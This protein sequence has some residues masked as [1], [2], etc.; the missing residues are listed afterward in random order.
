MNIVLATHNRHK[1]RELVPLLKEWGVTILTLDQ[2]PDISELEESGATILDNALLKARQVNKFTTLPSLA[3]DTGLEVDA[4]GGKP[5]V[6]SSR[7]AGLNATYQD[8]VNK[9]LAKLGS[10]PTEKRTARFR[11]VLAFVNCTHEFTVE[12]FLE[13]TITHTPR[14]TNGFGYDPVFFVPS[15]QKTVAELST[16]EKNRISHRGQALQ[17]FH[18][19]LP[20]IVEQTPQPLT[21][22]HSL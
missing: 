19:L 18:K 3:D 6:R 7:W 1:I 2:F 10:V 13:G 21:E 17:K 9:L 15:L 5:G 12:G 11:T 4:L 20:R 16:E 22:E 8:N 14:G